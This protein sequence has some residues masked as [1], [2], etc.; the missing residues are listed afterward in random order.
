MFL[1]MNQMTRIL[2]KKLLERFQS[3]LDPDSVADLVFKAVESKQ[4]YIF[5]EN[6]FQDAIKTRHRDIELVRNPMLGANLVEEH[7]NDTD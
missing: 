6:T 7:L 4:F 2:A 1:S 3:G 5:T